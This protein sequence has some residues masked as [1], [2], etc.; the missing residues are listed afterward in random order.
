MRV[1]LIATSVFA[2]GVWV[3]FLLL[4]PARKDSPSHQLLPI[5]E[6]MLGVRERTRGIQ[7]SS[8]RAG[9]IEFVATDRSF[10]LMRYRAFW[11][12][13][14]VLMKIPLAGVKIRDA[15][16]RELRATSAHFALSPGSL[17]GVEFYMEE[18]FRPISIRL[19]RSSLL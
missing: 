11:T 12:Q 16:G 9:T 4:D 5:L 1:T 17:I 3:G 8:S 10:L 14:S 19:I 6:T 13:E 18:R 7:G 2:L 15:D